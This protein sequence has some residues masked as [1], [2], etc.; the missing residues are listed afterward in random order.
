MNST[1]RAVR[2]ACQRGVLCGAV[3][4]FGT[5]VP[6]GGSGQSIYVNGSDV[7]GGVR[8]VEMTDVTRV[9]FDAEG[10]VHVVAPSID[11]RRPDGSPYEAD[12]RGMSVLLGGTWWL[13]SVPAPD[14][15]VP[16]RVAVAINGRLVATLE[17]D[18][19]QL[20][21]EITGFLAPGENTVTF[22]AMRVG[23]PSGVV[24]NPL[25]VIIGRGER[26]DGAVELNEVAATFERTGTSADDDATES[27][28]FTLSEPGGPN[29]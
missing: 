26:L 22:Q 29:R 2:D 28:T 9:Y 27:V 17:P 21:E 6:V 20:V 7:T 18:G 8:D 4:V 11:L 24:S 13:L 12:A 19:P 10:N 25:R 23:A 14:G 1:I 15:A 5:V 3:V 16:D